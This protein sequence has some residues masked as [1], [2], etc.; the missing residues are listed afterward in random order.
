MTFVNFVF[1]PHRGPVTCLMSPI[2]RNSYHREGSRLD[3]INLE[4]YC[5]LFRVNSTTE[6]VYVSGFLYE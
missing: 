3:L 1:V 5:I 2:G 4:V 6:Y